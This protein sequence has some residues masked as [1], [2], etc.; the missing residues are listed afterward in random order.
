[1]YIT[2]SYS[3]S[4]TYTC[5]ILLCAIHNIYPYHIHILMIGKWSLMDCFVMVVF[6]CAFYL[7]LS[8]LEGKVKVE[9]NILAEWG[10]Q[11]YIIAVLITLFLGHIV[12]ACHRR[13]LQYDMA[14]TDGAGGGYTEERDA[15]IKQPSAPPLIVSKPDLLTPSSMDSSLLPPAA[16]DK[17]HHPHHIAQSVV[18]EALC[19]HTFS[20][21][22][23]LIPS[24]YIKAVNGYHPTHNL[25]FSVG[26]HF[27][28]TG[29]IAL[30]TLLALTT[31][32][33]LIGTTIPTFLFT[34]QGL[35]GYILGPAGTN[36][37]SL[38]S[39]G[40]VYPDAARGSN[41]Y[42][43]TFFQICY[44]VFGFVMPLL[45]SILT[46]FLW[47]VPMSVSSQKRTLILTEIVN[48]WSAL[49]VFCVALIAGVLELPL[50]SLYTI[51][52]M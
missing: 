1:M 20:V 18:D 23:R 9:V 48:A 45:M 16:V 26:I 24:R 37:Y 15:L 14:L 43:I 27:T 17:D 38:A 32:G 3:Y 42:M 31:L 28:P 2:H 29:K 22:T 30:F 44:Y 5:R 51:L 4:Y 52:P 35:T 49:D 21:P 12:M 47:F 19:N 41:R 11:A 10:F 50:V 13:A 34:F 25:P 7:R 40:L 33:L 46:L 39:L 8:L 36:Q 6:A